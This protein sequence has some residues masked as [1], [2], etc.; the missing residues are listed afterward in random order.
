MRLDQTHL[1]S[2]DTQGFV[3]V[4]GFLDRD[5]VERAQS[6]MFEIFPRPEQ[7]FADPG[8]WP[9]F[10]ESQFTGIRHLPYGWDLD[11]L[12]FHPDLVDAAERVLST[13]DLRLYKVELWAKYSGAID[14]D[15][16]LHR[17][18]GNHTLVVPRSD[19]VGRQLTS[20]T[21]LSDVTEADGP[22]RIVPIE[23]TRHI[24]VGADPDARW[25]NSL[26]FGEL[27]DVEVPVVGPAG[28]L[29]LY[30]TDVF[31][32][33]SN[34]TEPRRSRFALLA[35]YEARGPTWTGKV[36]WPNVANKP[37]W[38]TMIERASVRERDL[39]GFPRV[40]DP[41]W[42]DETLAG[43]Q[44]RYPNLDLAPYRTSGVAEHR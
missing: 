28:T 15:Q 38:S 31:H 23:H 25:P 6:A 27:A 12:A 21:L 11:R 36:A 35:D 32:R 26:P 29:L 2:L 37:G 17:D 9:E 8:R 33:G 19:G 4:E 3:I 20:F 43:V 7:Y 18:F 40:G 10:G 42:N 41:Y 30:R 44:R 39:F 1:E 13:D 24:P 34:F 5:E 14:Y 16:P 22:T